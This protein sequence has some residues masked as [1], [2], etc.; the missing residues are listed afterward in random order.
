MEQTLLIAVSA[1]IVTFGSVVLVFRLQREITMRSRG[2][3]MWIPWADWLSFSSTAV[4][5]FL[6]IAPVVVAGNHDP[7]SSVAR[8]ATVCSVVL[9][10]GYPAAILS[11]YRLLFGTKRSG[12]YTNPE[13]AE[14]ALVI[15]TALVAI[16]ASALVALWPLLHE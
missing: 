13:P 6:V 12:P 9:L 1:A 16:A 15:A 7:W 3:P 11:H 14:K 4:A 5:L 10:A 2:E 8:S